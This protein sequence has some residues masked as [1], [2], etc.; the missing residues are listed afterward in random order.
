[1]TNQHHQSPKSIS[2]FCLCKLDMS[3]FFSGKLNKTLILQHRLN[4][5][6]SFD[7]GKLIGGFKSVSWQPCVALIINVASIPEEIPYGSMITYLKNLESN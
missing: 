3:D 4:F 5:I 6:V 7:W 2:I 1:M